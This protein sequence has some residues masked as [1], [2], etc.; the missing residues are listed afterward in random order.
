MRYILGEKVRFLDEQGTGIIKKELNSRLYIVET[1]YG[2]EI[3]KKIE[4]LVKIHSEDYSKSTLSIKDS[5]KKQF[6]K[7][8]KNKN[9]EIDLH[10]HQLIDNETS[11]TSHEKLLFQLTALKSYMSNKI[12]PKKV[13]EFVIIHGVGE[14]VLK[15]EIHAYLSGK[16]GVFFEQADFRKYGMG[17]TKVYLKYSLINK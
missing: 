1:D 7:N 4:D 8:S 12:Y 13:K 5:P 15:S 9:H 2:F 6:P 10:L 14:G 16:S 11:F 3:E 17:A